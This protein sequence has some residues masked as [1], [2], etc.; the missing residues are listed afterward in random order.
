MI[1]YEVNLTVD[2]EIEEAYGRWL[3]THIAEVIALD[4]FLDALWTRRDPPPD[5]RGGRHHY[6]VAY[7][8]RDRDAYEHYL[9]DHAPRLREDGVARFGGRFEASRRLHTV[10]NRYAAGDV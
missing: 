5:A 4:G 8:M 6:T 1:I 7:T 3:H 10:I 2:D 9:R